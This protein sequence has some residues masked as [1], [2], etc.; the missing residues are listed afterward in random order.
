MG[1]WES[2]AERS[3]RHAWWEEAKRQPALAAQLDQMHSAVLRGELTLA[4][5]GGITPEQ[6]E[7]AYAGAAKLVAI[8]KID[9]AQQ[10][11]GYLILID[12]YQARGY[13]L[14]GTCFHHKRRHALAVA[15]YEVALAFGEDAVTRMA[16]GEALLMLGRR[17]EARRALK[18]GIAA[19]P[20]HKSVQPYV[21]RA[22]HLLSTYLPRGD[23]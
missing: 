20:P 22:Q 10:I 9:E 17:P 2:D 19:A 5:A 8:G 6:L 21:Q 12:P 23:A 15:Y 11:A 14:A 7:A 3:E 1:I 4:Q 13:V 16:L 18:Q